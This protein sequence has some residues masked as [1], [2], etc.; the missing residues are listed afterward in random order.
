MITESQA[1]AV[2]AF[3]RDCQAIAAR[4]FYAGKQDQAAAF[5][6]RWIG[7]LLDCHA[8]GVAPDQSVAACRNTQASPLR[9][10][11]AK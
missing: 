9:M 1:G 7:L 5:V 4:R 6:M 8:A 2:V 10:G 11:V 3:L